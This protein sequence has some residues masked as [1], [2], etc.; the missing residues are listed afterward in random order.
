MV[1]GLYEATQ[2]AKIADE[3]GS[4]ED[5]NG[6]L[7]SEHT[8]TLDALVEKLRISAVADNI[9]LSAFDLFF[10]YCDSEYPGNPHFANH[11][12]YLLIASP[13]NRV[14]QAACCPLL[15]NRMSKDSFCRSLLYYSTR[16]QET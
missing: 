14:M 9:I 1:I 6:Y 8:N 4:F 16:R 13:K 5:I 2:N 10:T 15:T 7:L 12:E 3:I 11:F